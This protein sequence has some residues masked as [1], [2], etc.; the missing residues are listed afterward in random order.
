MSTERYMTDTMCLNV[1]VMQEP[2]AVHKM[3]SAS[4]YDLFYQDSEGQKS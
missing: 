4:F 2:R 3:T 1:N